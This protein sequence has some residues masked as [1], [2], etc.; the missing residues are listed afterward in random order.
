MKRAKV[1]GE[2]GMNGEHYEGGQFLPNTELPK[3]PKSQRKIRTGKVEIAPYVWEVAP[4]G[5]RSI[6]EKYSGI[7][8]WDVRGVSFKV[9]D[10]L[11]VEYY[12]LQAQEKAA[13]AAKRWNGGERW[14]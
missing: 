5:K 7:W 13:E 9:N 14:E 3:M 11:N 10:G 4:D 6:Y 8:M 12:G 2:T 1:G